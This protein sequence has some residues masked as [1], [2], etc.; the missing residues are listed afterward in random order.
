[1][2]YSTE[3]TKKYYPIKV[4]IPSGGQDIFTIKDISETF[5]CFA[6][7]VLPVVVRVNPLSY[8]V[9]RRIK[10]SLGYW[11]HRRFFYN[12]TKCRDFF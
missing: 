6:L 4:S 8:E 12:S 9:M 7:A 3:H 11:V 5:G 1:V 10:F 2:V